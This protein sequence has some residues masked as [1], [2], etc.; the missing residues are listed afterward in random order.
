MFLEIFRP[1]KCSSYS[2]S[3]HLLPVAFCTNAMRFFSLENFKYLC[4]QEST[5]TIEVLVMN[6]VY[7]K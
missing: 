4:F 1:K 6:F 5:I 3:T 2:F 7:A